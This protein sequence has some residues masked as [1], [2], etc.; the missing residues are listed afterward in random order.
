MRR[1]LRVVGLIAATLLLVSACTSSEPAPDTASALERVAAATM[2]V[3]LEG[4][5]AE[6]GTD[7]V[8]LT[9]SG[10]AFFIDPSGIA[11]TNNHVVT[12]AAII[13]VYVQGEDGPRNARIIGASECHD[14]AVLQ[15]DGS[16]FPALSWYAGAVAPGLEVYAAGFP[17]RGY[18]LTRGIVSQADFSVETEWASVDGALEHDARI[19]PGNSGGPLVSDDGR[20]VG[21]NYASSD[22]VA[23]SWAIGSERARSVIE[24]LQQGENIDSIGV[25]GIAFKDEEASVSG[26]W[27]TSVQTGSTAFDVGVRAGDVITRLNGLTIGT[28]GTMADYCDVL[29]STQADAQI[30]IQIYRPATDQLL[31]G[32][33]NGDRLEETFS[34][35]GSGGAS[36]LADYEYGLITDNSGRIVVEVPTAWTDI[37][38]G[39]YIDER[40]NQIFD[41]I[42][43]EDVDAFI[44]TFDVSGVRISASYD[45]ARSTNERDILEIYFR[46]FSTLCTFAGTEEYR[47]A[48]YSGE[49]D[50]YTDCGGTDASFYVVA[51]V[52]RS[53]AF[54]IWIEGVIRSDADLLALDRIL[55]SFVFN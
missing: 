46:E 13:R 27:V 55:D 48:F 18:T 49:F 24:R 35:A 5:F 41:V 22:F 39:S 45:L 51:V 33:L 17:E 14:L 28:G 54:V 21:I 20:V 42:V 47:D 53:R 9:F 12:G 7:E 34:F 43:A 2:R 4:A 52:P 40:G 3:E 11:V 10:S 37:D 32:I 31:E 23:Q 15:I 29:R 50:A 6:F 1:R 36:G 44:E 26:V 38:G 25:N 30:R 19:L 8:E 16:D